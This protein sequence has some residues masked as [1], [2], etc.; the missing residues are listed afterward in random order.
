MK[1]SIASEVERFKLMKKKNVWSSVSST[2][3][4]R[5]ESMFRSTLSVKC[6][7]VVLVDSLGQKPNCLEVIFLL[8]LK[9]IVKLVIHGLFQNCA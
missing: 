4:K 1:T 5:P 9:K 2:S 7:K 3:V 6:V 8:A